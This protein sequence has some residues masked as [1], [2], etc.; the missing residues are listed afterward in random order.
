MK[1]LF[2]NN[3][4]FFWDFARKT[5][6]VY[7]HPGR[8]IVIGVLNLR[9]CSCIILCKQIFAQLFSEDI[10]CNLNRSKVPAQ[11]QHGDAVVLRNCIWLVEYWNSTHCKRT[12]RENPKK[13]VQGHKKPNWTG[14]SKPTQHDRASQ[15]GATRVAC[16]QFIMLFICKW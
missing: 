9:N 1:K 7:N 13:S 10:G 12:P 2:S 4:P 15:S 6:A 16:V 3:D 11:M 5:G 8:L 14:L